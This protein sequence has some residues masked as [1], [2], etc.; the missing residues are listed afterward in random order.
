MKY[1][2]TEK[3]EDRLIHIFV[4]AVV[5]WFLWSLVS[6]ETTPIVTTTTTTT[7]STT[8]T[9]PVGLSWDNP[10]RVA[11]SNFLMAKISNEQVFSGLDEAKDAVKFCSN[12]KT[13]PRSEQER[14][15]AEV[16]I[17]VAKFESA[18]NPTTTYIETQMGID[19]IT[20]IRIASEGLLQLSYQDSRH[21][22]FCNEFDYKADRQLPEKS[23]KRTILNPY[24]NL[25]CGV[26]IM[27][28]LARKRKAVLL[29]D[30]PHYWSVLMSGKK[31]HQ[32][33]I[34]ARVKS[35]MGCP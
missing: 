30:R 16:I 29:D 25:N 31:H 12:Y 26:S 6:C 8:T 7:L 9:L 20:K 34:I 32:A 19:P 4:L 2:I 33:E 35:K 27:A 13:L 10:E 14:M 28:E 22:S 5:L 11:W 18:W 24:K 23:P 17:A 3:M 21:W 15:W 1:G